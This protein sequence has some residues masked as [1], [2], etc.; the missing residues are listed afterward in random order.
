MNIL[1]VQNLRKTYGSS[2]AEINALNQVSSSVYIGELIAII[3]E[4]GTPMASLN[5]RWR[6]MPLCLA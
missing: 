3:G 5:G 6:R 2:E 4:S 1:E